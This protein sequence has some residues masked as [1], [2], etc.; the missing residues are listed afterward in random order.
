MA[1]RLRVGIVGGG[2]IVQGQHLPN[3]LFLKDEIEV[4]GVA[5]P[6]AKARAFIESR[7]GVPTFASGDELRGRGGLDAILV[8]SPDF[9]HAREV[10][11]SLERGLHVFCE[12]PLCYGV[13]EADAIVAARDRAGRVVQVGYMKRH[14]PS[15]EACLDLLPGDGAGLRYVSVEVND[16]DAWPFMEPHPYVQGDDVPA[17][18]IAEGRGQQTAQIER[19]LGG[20]VPDPIARGFATAYCSALVH[21]VNLVHGM[22]DRMGVPDGEVVGAQLFAGGDGGLGTVRLLGGRAVWQMTHL[23]VPRLADYRERVTVYLD[24]R[25]VELVF[26]SP[27]LNHHPTRLVEKRSDGLT[28]STREIRPGFGEAFVRELQAFH[29]SATEGAPVRNTPEQ[30]RRDQALLCGLA[31]H[32]AQSAAGT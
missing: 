7:F 21:D 8:A 14:D 28:L 16:P 19:A 1:R 23:T 30:A 3:L 10:L 32:A 6:S 31:R 13:E 9:T 26:P 29:A 11:A 24:D 27:W 22:L 20:P 15:Y 17:D 18:L 4:A 2:V 25:I 12:K 5:D